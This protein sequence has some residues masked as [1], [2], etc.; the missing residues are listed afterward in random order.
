[1]TLPPQPAVVCPNRKWTATITD[2]DFTSA[3][4]TRIQGGE[5]IFTQELPA[6]TAICREGTTC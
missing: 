6:M 1:M 2:V 5:V 4:L 3:T